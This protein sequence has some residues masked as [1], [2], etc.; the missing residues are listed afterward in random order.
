MKKN[1]KLIQKLILFLLLIIVIYL[2]AAICLSLISTSPKTEDCPGDHVVYLASNGIHL[3]ILIEKEKLDSR[4]LDK[5]HKDWSSRYIGFGWGD[6]GFYLNTPTWADLKFK[7]VISSMFLKSETAMHITSYFELRQDY[8]KVELCDS[9]MTKLI[10]FIEES[11]KVNPDGSFVEIENSGYTQYDYFYNAKGSYNCINTCNE[12]V[13]DGL[14]VADIK[15]SIWSP[16]DR[17]IL[18]QMKKRTNRDNQRDTN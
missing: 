1:I 10:S 2:L 9:Q 11:F 16:F 8:I 5:L 14:K 15:T 17:G 12:W 3:D 4:I 18:Y 6:K 7:T 13:N